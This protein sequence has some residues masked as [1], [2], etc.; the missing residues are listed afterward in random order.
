MTE[1]LEDVHV[2]VE[3][4]LLGEQAYGTAKELAK[5]VQDPELI[6]EVF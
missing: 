6:L 5:K 4:S 2:A 1:G 3:V